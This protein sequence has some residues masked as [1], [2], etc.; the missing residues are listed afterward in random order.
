MQTIKQRHRRAPALPW[1]NSPLRTARG[2]QGSEAAERR[3][4][5]AGLG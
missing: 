4:G 1:R 5:A 3:D 2:A